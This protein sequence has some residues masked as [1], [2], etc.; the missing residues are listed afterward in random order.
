MLTKAH[1][2][3]QQGIFNVLDF[4]YPLFKHFFSIQQFRYAACGGGNT[5]LN[6]FMYFIAYNFILERQLTHLG[7]LSIRPHIAAFLIAFC[8]SFP[9]GFYLN[10]YIVFHTSPLRK[11]TQA[12]RYLLTISICI[13]LNYFFL[14]LFVEI[15]NWYPTPSMM[16]TTVFITIFSYISQNQ[17]SFKSVTE[18]V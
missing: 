12:F 7:L 10:R 4:I 11:R 3:I 5:V 13:L 6:I 18:R 1:N 2:N 17:F 8:V 9:I 15:L 14:K 16:L